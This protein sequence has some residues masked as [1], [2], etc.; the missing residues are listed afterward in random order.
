MKDA[1]LKAIKHEIQSLLSGKGQV[2][3]GTLIQTISRYLRTSS[4][5]GSMAQASQQNKRKEAE[6]L[7]KYAEEQGLW[8]K[9]I[10]FSNFISAGAEQRVFI[11]DSYHLIKLNDTVYYA[12][13]LDYFQS[14][15]LNNFFFP[16]TAYRFLG[17]YLQDNVLHAVVEQP[18]VVANKPT[19][20]PMVKLFMGNNSFENTRNHD[21]YHPVLGI[22]L[23]DLHDEN[24]LT[25]N[26]ILFFIDTVFYIRP[27][28]LWT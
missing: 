27:E 28:V 25:Q 26:S 5:T 1:P 17:F 22:I 18:F 20:L 16:D 12:S 7:T 4:P 8:V 24:V 21:Y 9:D 23:E 2:C 3:Q 6:R 14:L 11:K 15:L 19:D 13:W 10:R